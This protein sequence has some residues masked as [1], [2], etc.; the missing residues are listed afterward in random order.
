MR[1]LTKGR[2]IIT[3]GAG[4]IGSALIWALNQKGVDNILVVD[5]LGSSEKYLNLVPLQFED[6]L[7][8]DWL[9]DRIHHNENYFADVNFVHHLGANSNTTEKDA[10]Y[11]IENNFAYTKTLAWWALRKGIR[12]LYASSAATYGLGEQGMSDRDERD[13]KRLRPL[14]MYAYSKQLFDQYALRYGLLEQMIGIKYFNIFGPNEY[15][16]GDMRSMVCKA[17][18]QIQDTGKVQ[19]FKSHHPD[20]RD[21]EQLRDFLYVKDAVEMTIFLCAADECTGLYNIGA[22]QAHTWIELVA[23]I[24]EALGTEMSVET[25]DMPRKLRK[26]YQYYTKADIS[27]IGESGYSPKITPLHE[28]VT[29]YVRDYLLPGKCLGDE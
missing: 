26:H 28:A 13:I 20:Y 17:F 21:G 23:P 25:I 18:E 22:G 27:K 5:K 16:K 2:H 7:E 6:Y 15:H 4:F 24:F 1:D 3:G 11:L 12:F 9:L 10:R 29:E 14:N 19:L 8:S